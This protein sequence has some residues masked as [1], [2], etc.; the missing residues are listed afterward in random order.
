MPIFLSKFVS[1]KKMLNSLQ[2]YQHY[3]QQAQS[4]AN[5]WRQPTMRARYFVAIAFALFIFSSDTLYS[6]TSKIVGRITD[7][8]TGEPL[9]GA[10]I[11]V[12][13]STLGTVTN[14]KGE[15]ELTVSKGVYSVQIK[16]VGYETVVK[17]VTISSESGTERINVALSGLAAQ[18]REV[19]V[20]ASKGKAE[21]KLDAPITIETATFESIRQTASTSP[22]GTLAKLKGVDFVERGINTVDVSSRGLNTQFNTRMLTLIDGRL[23]TLPGLGLPQFALAPNP[24]LDIASI[25]VA[26]GPAAALYGPNAHA[27]VVN[28]ITKNPFDYAG[29]EVSIRGGSQSLYDLS[30]RY[31]DHIGNIGWKVTSQLMEADQFESGNFFLFRAPDFISQNQTVLNPETPAFQTRANQAFIDDL[32]RLGYVFDETELS[33]MKA[34]LRKIDGGLYYRGETFSARAMAGYSESTGFLGSNFGVLE[35][36]GYSINYQSLQ[37]NGQLGKL[38]WF[39]QVTRTSNDA[40]KS[41]QIHDRAEQI[42]R[43]VATIRSQPGNGT[44]TREEVLSRVNYAV[45]DSAAGVF[46]ESSL[47]DSEVQL[48]YDLD[49]FEF[50][51]GFQYRYYDPRATFLTNGFYRPDADITAT[52]IGTY[53]QIDKRFFENRLRLSLAGRLDNHTYYDP[54]FSPKATA[55]WSVL[56]DHNVRV[57]FNRAFKV[58]VILENHLFLF[59][60]AARGNLNGYT[61]RNSADRDANGNPTGAILAQY[62]PLRPESVNSF[63]VGYK[64]L[65]IDK[66]LF[67]DVVAYYSQYTNFISPA[68]AISDGVRTFAFNSDGTL[69]GFDPT[70]GGSGIPGQ[71]TTYFNYGGADIY[72]F[73]IGLSYFFTADINLDLNA[74]FM[75]F[76]STDNQFAS[77][78]IP[79]QLNAPTNKYKATLALRNQFGKG[80]FLNLHGRHIPGYTFRA[81]RWNGTLDDRTVVDLTIGYEWKSLGATFQ[82]GINNIFDNKTPDVLGSPI[83]R[84]F[85]SATL[86][87]G[88]SGFAN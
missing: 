81:G 13:A 21:K 70:T 32:R 88:I 51:G 65:T 36:N 29:A 83:M 1:L 75:D 73:D 41:F 86:T 77:Q 8:E 24:S 69:S 30:A 43:Q 64:G 48:R 42:A 34:S 53:L 59:N 60:G 55:V 31:A 7:A 23:A 78:G 38:G 15:F 71:L 82:I 79:I 14:Q 18:S 4:C 10:S 72:G 67:I 44:L 33:A 74:S 3:V 80:T 26:V 85:V 61:V 49:G 22:L 35:A 25:E 52:E 47:I 57:G 6:Q 28:M 16:Y 17:K 39:A 9:V 50:T 2:V 19:V 66:K 46:D 5:N 54:Q 68:F 58:P 20:T 40:G 84:R 12:L 63:E 76:A 37:L 56:P 45:V 62:D 11:R 87:Y 27:G